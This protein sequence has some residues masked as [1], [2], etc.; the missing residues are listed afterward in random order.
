MATATQGEATSWCAGLAVDECK[1]RRIASFHAFL[2]SEG[3]A[4]ERRHVYDF[5]DG[6]LTRD[7]VATLIADL[8]ARVGRFDLVIAGYWHHTAYPHPDHRAVWHEVAT[9]PSH[10]LATADGPVRASVSPARWDGLFR[11]CDGTW[12]RAYGWLRGGCWTAET[13]PIVR[14]QTFIVRVE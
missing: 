9:R 10:A 13:P 3:L 1:A 6:D 11:P 2:D 8:E 12:Q 7:E 5:G 4:P 14:G